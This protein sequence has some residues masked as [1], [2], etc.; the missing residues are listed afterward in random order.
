MKEILS[1]KIT[2]HIR[3]FELLRNEYLNDVIEIS[4]KIVKSLKSGGKI[5]IFGNGGSAADAQHFAG[6][7]V[8]R[9]KED[10]DGFAAMA[11]TNDSSIITSVGNDY[12]YNAIF[13][14]QVKA[15]AKSED[16][17]FGI[18]TSGNSENV[19]N[20]IKVATVIGCQTIC[21]LGK[22]GGKL[23]ELCDD[24]VVIQS[25]NT[26][27]IQECHGFIIHVLCDLIERGMSIE[28]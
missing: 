8:G 15:L 19:I 10:R 24:C 6:E 9:F 28:N 11:L 21:L 22:N 25:D 18:S 17:V 12:G 13:E 23:K 20:G 16:I 27:R 4:E 3:L 14:R 7:L 5:L 2:E 1:A 26:Q